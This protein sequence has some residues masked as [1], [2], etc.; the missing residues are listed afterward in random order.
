MGRRTHVPWAR[1]SLLKHWAT[2]NIN[3]LLW[4]S[5]KYIA[6]ERGEKWEEARAF[7]SLYC[8]HA[9]KLLLVTLKLMMK[10]ED[11]KNF[12]G[13]PATTINNMKQRLNFFKKA[14]EIAQ[15]IE[16]REEWEDCKNIWGM[17]ATK[18]KIR[19]SDW[20]LWGSAKVVSINRKI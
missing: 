19:Y 15:E 7:Q 14:Q 3:R 4:E 9:T 20:I 16:D 8:L 1:R 10:R 5:P 12:R 11:C 18:T 6:L 2:S 13:M 17:R